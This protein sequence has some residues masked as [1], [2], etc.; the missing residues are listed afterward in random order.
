MPATATGGARLSKSQIQTWNTAHLS[1]AAAA[2]RAAAATSEN[3][4]D[5]HRA[6]VAS[7]GGTTWEGDGKD[8][9]LDRA[10]TDTVVVSR[11]SGVLR[12]AADL[13]E[14]GAYDINNAQSEAVAAITAAEDDDFSVGE[15]LKVTDT[16]RYDITTIADRNK[17]LAEHTEDIRWYADRLM[18]TDTHVGERLQGKA[19]ELDEIKFDGEGEDRAGRNGHVWLVDNKVKR[20]DEGNGGEKPTQAPG[21]IGPFAVP[22]SVADAA[23]KPG[24]KAP[25]PVADPRA[26]KSLE[27]MLLPEGMADPTKPIAP[28]M[29]PAQVEEMRTMSRRLLQQQGVPPDQIEGRV[30]AMVADAQRVHAALAENPRSTGPTGPAPGKPSYSDGFRDAWQNMENTV[31]SLTGQN[32]FESFKDAW[33]DTGAGL[34]ETLSDPYGSAARRVEAEIEAFR[35]NPEYWVGQK[36]FEAGVTAATLP[37]GG[38]L[39]AARGAVGDVVSPPVPHDVVRSPPHVDTPAPVD[40]PAPLT[41][42]IP[43]EH[44]TPVTHD[45]PSDHSAPVTHDA[46][47]DQPAPEHSSDPPKRPFPPE[48]VP[49][50]FAYDSDGQ[51]LPY[52]NG[53]RPPF[54]ETQVADVWDLSRAEQVMGIDNGHINLT[55]PGPDQQ[56]VELHPNKPIGEDWTVENGHRLIEWRDG[57]PRT[58]LWDMG[59]NGGSEYRD[60]LK[61]YLSGEKSYAEFIKEYQDANNYRVQDP[62]RNRSHMDEA[63]R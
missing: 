54:G 44:P 19:A 32:G 26:P 6:N 21:Q 29:T 36:G 30:N 62:S 52:A 25:G 2:W 14:N 7:P 35:N 38:E 63:G 20:D 17:A 53:G 55:Q 11:Q 1:D 31:H 57:E 41:P 40:R 24:E 51:R 18:Q 28:P 46:P 27:G 56:W 45:A 15:D 3:L 58:G 43:P 50:S 37:F 59:H 16:R 42:D 49:N 39:A 10:T 61:E 23:K 33:K 22:R 4:F 34:V 12:E 47:A 13:A 5:Q 60:S 9:A 48:G 8:A